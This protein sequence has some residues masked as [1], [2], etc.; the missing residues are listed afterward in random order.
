V[1]RPRPRR[2]IRPP[3]AVRAARITVPTVVITALGVGVAGAV[4]PGE[5]AQ[6]AYPAPAPTASVD[7][8]PSETIARSQEL[9]R[10]TTRPPVRVA[11]LPKPKSSASETIAPILK[12]KITDRK[13]A[14]TDLNVR[15]EPRNGASVVAEVDKGTKLAVTKTIQ[16]G[17]RY[18][19]YRSKGRWVKNKYLSDTK[20]KSTSSG[21]GGGGG[22]IS[23]APCPGGS[24]VESA[25]TPDA[26]RVHRAL[27]HRYPQFTSFLGRRSSGGNHGSGRALD[28]MIS[29][30]SAGWDAARWVRANAKS[31]GVSEVIYRQQ[32]WTVQ[33]SS[34]GWRSMSDR[35]SPTANHM[36]HV[37]VSVYGNSGSA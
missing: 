4:M 1:S 23:G 14:T 3:L 17:F 13:Y 32:I 24:S 2:A 16:N 10:G 29:D 37:H 12:L 26:I 34:D 25:L 5:D 19:S 18:V 9:S 27:C 8:S 33:R 35:G 11:A 20:P 22:G 6:V 36:D 30:S 28:C 21:G 15:T 7:S 31:L